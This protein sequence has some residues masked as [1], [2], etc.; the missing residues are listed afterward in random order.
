MAAKDFNKTLDHLGNLMKT[1]N[2]LTMKAAPWY[3]AV[4]AGLA[5]GYSE[6]ADSYEAGARMNKAN[7]TPF[8]RQVSDYR[9]VANRLQLDYA[10]KF[11]KFESGFAEAQVPMHFVVPPGSAAAVVGLAK[12][13][14][15]ILP[16]ATEIDDIQR[17]VL[18]RSVLMAMAKLTGSEK[19]VTRAREMLKEGTAS[20]PREV[21]FRAMAETLFDA[22]QLYSERKLSQPDK[23][24]YFLTHSLEAL[25]PVPASKDKKEMEDKINGLLKKIKS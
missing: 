24:K 20:V 22:A 19:D 16:T 14:N 5:S 4:A 18:E 12:V 6:L 13:G 10:E 8:R 17:K 9:T 7:P 15:G 1:E 2:P 3:L 21:F 23:M 25:R 11:E